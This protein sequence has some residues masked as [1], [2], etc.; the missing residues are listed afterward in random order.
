MD[1]EVGPVE[2]GYLAR[3]PRRAV[4]VAIVALRRCGAVTAGQ[5]G[6]VR[7]KGVPPGWADPVM[8]AVIGSL[9]NP[10]GSRMIRR[11]IAVDRA[12]VRTRRRL[13]ERQLLLPLWLRF[14]LPLVLLGAGAALFR[15]LSW[16]AGGAM[17]LAVVSLR[18]PRRTLAGWRAVRAL[19][20]RY[21]VPEEA[22]LDAWDSGMVVAV[23]GTLD[24][25]GVTAFARRTRLRTGGGWPDRGNTDAIDTVGGGST[26]GGDAG[27]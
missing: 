15:P 21:R 18:W 10:M 7:R 19:R 3:G 12:L 2:A 25:P 22:P 20:R 14:L 1:V 16:E 13:V 5:H 4:L 17:A 23:H 27:V 26:G 6:T 8:R 24:F 11:R 9:T